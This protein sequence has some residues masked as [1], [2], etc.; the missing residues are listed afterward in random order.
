MNEID[1][2]DIKYYFVHIIFILQILK[3]SLVDYNFM[4]GFGGVF[5]EQTVTKNKTQ[6]SSVT[7]VTQ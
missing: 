1:T 5:T 3:R 6:F 2:N 7:H 4:A